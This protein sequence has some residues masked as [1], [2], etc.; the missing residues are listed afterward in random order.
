MKRTSLFSRF[1]FSMGLCLLVSSNVF[2][3]EEEDVPME[4]VEQPFNLADEIQSLDLCL[5]GH[6]HDIGLVGFKQRLQD[7]LIRASNIAEN[8]NDQEFMLP[9]DARVEAIRDVCGQL[10][11]LAAPRRGAAWADFVVLVVVVSNFQ[12]RI[13]KI[14][15]DYNKAKEQALGLPEDSYSDYFI[16]CALAINIGIERFL[17]P[18]HRLA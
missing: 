17:A 8:E 13:E 14:Y 5:G 10:N 2:A 16:D 15:Q 9:E 4:V 7:A 3:I 18:F 1:L 12:R 6:G 11:L